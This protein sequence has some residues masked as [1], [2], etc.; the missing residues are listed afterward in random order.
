MVGSINPFAVRGGGSAPVKRRNDHMAT[1]KQFAL[2]LETIRPEWWALLLLACWCGVRFSEAAELRQHDVKLD[3]GVLRV[4]RAVTRSKTQGI[5]VKGAQVRRRHPRR[6]HPAAHRP[7]TA[8]AP[9]DLRQR[10]G[11]T[12]A[13]RHTWWPPGSGDLYGKLTCVACKRT[14]PDCAR[15]QKRVAEVQKHHFTPRETGWYAARTGAGCPALHFHDLRATA[16][17]TK[18]AEHH[19]A[20]LGDRWEH[21]RACG[22]LA[23]SLV[24]CGLVED[25]V[26]TATA[27]ATWL[28]DVGCAPELRQTGFHSLDGALF[29][30][31]A[32]APATIVGLSPTTPGPVSR[33]R[34]G[35]DRCVRCTPPPGSIYARHRHAD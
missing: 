22:R 16:E 25:E 13:P 8:R 20:E 19:L 14:P 2:M 28:H 17:A 10:P 5:G 29:L 26:A 31:E 15:A 30:R 21:V 32:G 11:R 33:L 34:S 7:R 1:G 3:I 4:T 23:G 12:D 9:A 18:L 24:Y 35:A 6:P 27:T